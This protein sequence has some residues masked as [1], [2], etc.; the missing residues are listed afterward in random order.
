MRRHL[1]LVAVLLCLSTRAMAQNT[2]PELFGKALSINANGHAVNIAASGGLTATQ[3]V[4]GTYTFTET[5]DSG[6]PVT[7][8]CNGRHITFTRGSGSNS[9]AY[10]GWM[11]EKILPGDAYRRMGGVFSHGGKQQYGWHATIAPLPPH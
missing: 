11:F 8:K 10:D 3:P 2:C 5:D 9:Q 1:F 6:N 7:I 4:N